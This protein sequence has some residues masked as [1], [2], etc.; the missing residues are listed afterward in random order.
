M[1]TWDPGPQPEFD[2]EGW[3]HQPPPRRRNPLW[4]RRPPPHNKRNAVTGA[5]PIEFIQPGEAPKVVGPA[6]DERYLS[7]REKDRC[8]ACPDSRA[9]VRV[10]TPNGELLFCG[11]HYKRYEPT[12]LLRGYEVLDQRNLLNRERPAL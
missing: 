9:F 7:L 10:V 2:D 6:T 5:P 8:D 1:S 4:P 12:I 11:H 3:P